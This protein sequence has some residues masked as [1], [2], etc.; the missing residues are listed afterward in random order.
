VKRKSEDKNIFSLLLLFAITL[1]N[2]WHGL[3]AVAQ[4][5]FVC[6]GLLILGRAGNILYDAS[7]GS[8]FFGP[9]AS[10]SGTDDTLAASFNGRR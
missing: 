1:C 8:D 2:Q 6:F 5:E 10:A 4:L 9:A 7:Q 3:V